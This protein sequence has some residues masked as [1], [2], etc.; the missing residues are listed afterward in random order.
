MIR[1]GALNGLKARV[2]L[3]LC[4]AADPSTQNVADAFQAS[5]MSSGPVLRGEATIAVKPGEPS[6]RSATGAK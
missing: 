3:S 4:L 5:G 6:V 1:A 2:L